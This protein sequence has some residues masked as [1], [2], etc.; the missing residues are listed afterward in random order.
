MRC[1][2]CEQPLIHKPRYVQLIGWARERDVGGVNAL[3]AK[4]STGKVWCD[5]CGNSCRKGRW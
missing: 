4:R 5:S 2:H 1:D 3:R